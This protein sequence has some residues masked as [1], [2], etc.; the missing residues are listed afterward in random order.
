MT[1]Y[2][3]FVVGLTAIA[4]A[5]YGRTIVLTTELIL[6]SITEVV[7]ELGCVVSRNY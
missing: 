2:N 3:T 4:S 6:P 1:V 7:L 5:E